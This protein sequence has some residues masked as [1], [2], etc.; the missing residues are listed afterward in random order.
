M[1]TQRYISNPYLIDGFKCDLRIYVLVSE[2]VACSY[3]S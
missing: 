2:S 3:Q 1:G